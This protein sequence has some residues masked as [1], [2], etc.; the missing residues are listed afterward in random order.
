MNGRLHAKLI[1]GFVAGF[2]LFAMVLGGCGDDDQP[3][4]KSTDNFI[5]KDTGGTVS[6]GALV[7]VMVPPEAI[8]ADAEIQIAETESIPALPDG[9]GFASPAYE[10][11]LSAGRITDT[12]WISVTYYDE[13]L[14]EGQL[15]AGLL[16]G[17]VDGQGWVFEDPEVESG[18]NHAM[19]GA[20]TQTKW[21][22]IWKTQDPRETVAAIISEVIDDIEHRLWDD[23]ALALGAGDAEDILAVFQD[24]KN[25]FDEASAENPAVESAIMSFLGALR[26]IENDNRIIMAQTAVELT[27]SFL[28]LGR[29]VDY[30]I[31]AGAATP[32]RVQIG[33]RRWLP[34][35]F[36]ELFTGALDYSRAGTAGTAGRLQDLQAIQHDFFVQL[37]YDPT[38]GGLTYLDFP[39]GFEREILTLASEVN[40]IY[41]MELTR[42]NTQSGKTIRFDYLRDRKIVLHWPVE[43]EAVFFNFPDVDESVNSIAVVVEFG[44]VLADFSVVHANPFANSAHSDSLGSWLYFD[45]P[46][47]A[48]VDLRKQDGQLHFIIESGGS[49]EDNTYPFPVS[50][51][52]LLSYGDWIEPTAIT[53]LAV[54]KYWGNSVRLGWTATGNDLDEGTATWY[55]LRYYSSPITEENW[56]DAIP[57]E[58]EPV[59]LSAGST[60]EFIL[61]PYDLSAATYLGLKVFDQDYNASALSNIIPLSALSELVVGIPDNNLRQALREVAGK[62]EGDIYGSDLAGITSFAA[63]SRGIVVVNG[64][65][66]LADVVFLSLQSNGQIRDLSPLMHLIDLRKLRLNANHINNISALRLMSQLQV[67]NLSSNTALS[68]ISPLAGLTQLDSLNLRYDNVSDAMPLVNLRDLRYLNLGN[69]NIMRLDGLQY[70]RGITT[71]LLN[72]NLLP[73]ITLLLDNPGLD[74]GD[75]LDI[76]GNEYVLW[77]WTTRNIEIPTLEERGVVVLYDTSN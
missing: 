43:A 5:A 63:N 49:I 70:L 19:I 16:I 11:S 38:F 23:I 52:P 77:E 8:S 4:T 55:D 42:V 51:R 46:A 56:Q 60:E 45:L 57:L 21:A 39:E 24:Y 61:L 48:L 13:F 73:N 75:T 15:E 65:E 29:A 12:I 41:H 9:Y 1:A 2:M 64:L 7:T 50:R 27:N 34:P 53:D 76:R 26:A 40:G 22:V 20:L 67:L 18:P 32:P 74:A 6:L 69:N 14:P 36:V 72:D 3:P 59:P 35:A 25:H 30:D 17:R 71:L 66:F 68:D 37:N 47:S 44:D 28:E 10:V 58:G 54:D 31:E 33:S 62:P